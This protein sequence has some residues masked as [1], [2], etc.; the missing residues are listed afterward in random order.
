MPVP[1]TVDDQGADP[2]RENSRPRRPARS[3]RHR[4]AAGCPVRGSAARPGASHH[5]PAKQQDPGERHD[6][7]DGGSRQPRL[8]G[9]L[10]ESQRRHRVHDHAE[11]DA[12]TGADGQRGRGHPRPPRRHRQDGRH[13]PGHDD[14]EQ[15]LGEPG[16]LQ[17][18][19]PV[20]SRRRNVPHLSR[21][22]WLP[23]RPGPPRTR[24]PAG[25]APAGCRRPARGSRPRQQGSPASS[26]TT[27]ITSIRAIAVANLSAEPGQASPGRQRRRHREQQPAA[28]PARHQRLPWLSPH[29][30]G[31][32]GQPPAARTAPR[33]L[34]PRPPRPSRAARPAPAT[35]RRAAAVAA[36]LSLSLNPP[37]PGSACS[38]HTGSPLAARPRR[39]ARPRRPALAARLAAPTRRPAPPSRWPAR[40]AV[41]RYRCRRGRPGAG[42]SCQH[43]STS[44]RS[45]S[46]IKIGYS[47]PDFSPVCLG[48]RIPVP[49]LRRLLAQRRQHRQRLRRELRT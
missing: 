10:S 49:P 37:P 24:R 34:R 38:W 35:A 46:R 3:W 9:V 41:S 17:R 20:G 19:P 42:S 2:G 27:V 25:T 14:Q 11:R 12:R 22:P 1:R 21:W 26:S 4:P 15:D 45:A 18:R 31:P 13:V 44:P 47:V 36:R 5:R 23:S 40:R 8:G 16:E 29:P 43:A 32:P 28:D 33:P 48:Q 7:V 30:A 6:R 39:R